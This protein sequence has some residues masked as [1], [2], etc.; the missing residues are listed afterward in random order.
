MLF[1]L[2]NKMLN[3][4]KKKKKIYRRKSIKKKAS[5]MNELACK[6]IIF[7]LCIGKIYHTPFSYV[8]QQTLNY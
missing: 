1:E 2:E 7:F 3:G 8:P 4:D 6:G 5:A